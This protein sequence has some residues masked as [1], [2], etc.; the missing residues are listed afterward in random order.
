MKRAILLAGMVMGLG[1]A[2]RAADPDVMWRERLRTKTES[3][4]SQTIATNSQVAV[5]DAGSVAR[6]ALLTVNKCTT[7]TVATPPAKGSEFTIVLVTAGTNTSTFA[8]GGILKLAGAFVGT[9]D[10]VLELFSA[11]GTNWFEVGR[12]AN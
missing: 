8:D 1:L 10:D 9:D 6:Y 2:A 11:D 4:R 7:N 5:S 12:S 3:Y